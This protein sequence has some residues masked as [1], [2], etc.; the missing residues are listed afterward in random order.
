MIDSGHLNFFE[1]SGRSPDPCN[2]GT[3]CKGDF[4][5]RSPSHSSPS[6]INV[7]TPAARG[8]YGYNPAVS[9]RYIVFTTTCATS[10]NQYQG[11]NYLIDRLI[12]A[13]QENQRS[14]W[15]RILAGPARDTLSL[16]SSLAA[17]GLLECLG[18]KPVVSL[19]ILLAL[20]VIT[21]A[22][23][24]S[25]PNSPASQE[26]GGEGKDRGPAGDVQAWKYRAHP[27][28]DRSPSMR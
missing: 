12:R 14:N 2:T 17:L 23:G 7:H 6:T 27:R 24:Y 8:K 22:V 3:I 16:S 20:P 5:A 4:N 1:H 19:P 21:A 9:M 10:L 15:Q 11:C 13:I 28:Q 26:H 25:K 18:A